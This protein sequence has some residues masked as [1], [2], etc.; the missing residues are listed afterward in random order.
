MGSVQQQ[1]GAEELQNRF[2]RLLTQ[3]AE[4]K[5]FAKPSYVNQLLEICRR[6]LGSTDGV[7]FLYNEIGN[8]VDAGIFHQTDWQHPNFLQ[9]HLTH[10]AFASSNQA[11]ITLE[12]LS[13][14]RWLALANGD[15]AQDHVSPDIARNF[16]REV[17]ALN[18]DLVFKHSTETSRQRKL[19]GV[20]HLFDFLVA[21]IGYGD[22]LEQVVNEVWRILKQRP[23]INNHIIAMITQLAVCVADPEIATPRGSEGLVSA[24]FG[25]TPASQTDPGLEYYQ[26]S[27]ES[28]DTQSLQMEAGAF[29]RAMHDTGLVSVYHTV[30]LRYVLSQ[31]STELVIQALGLSSTGTDSYMTYRELVNRLITDA[32]T[33]NTAQAVI[34]LAC[35][36]ERGILFDPSLAP[37]FWRLI[38]LNLHPE[39]EADIYNAYGTAQPAKTVL[40]AGALLVLGL[41]FGIGQ[42][43]NPTCQAARALS[44]WSYSDPN[45][46]MQIIVWAS[47][48]QDVSMHF[49][50]QPI[51]SKNL[52][53]E[54]GTTF[55]TELDPVSLVTVP[56]LDRIYLEM[57]RLS[58]GRGEDPHK[59]VNPEFHGWW[60]GQGFAIAVDINT[61]NLINH[62]QFIRDFYAFYHPYFNGNKP[63]IYPQPAGIAITDSFGDYV[64]WHAITIIRVNLDIQGIM[65]VYF[66]NPNN[67]S[68]QDWGN[69]VKVST[70]GNGELYGQSSL[71]IEQF[72]SRLYIFHYDP[73]EK[74]DSSN[75]EQEE[76]DAICTMARESWA[77]DRV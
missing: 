55:H 65:R 9:S 72:V 64:G 33:P 68:G 38:L 71:P 62:E 49:E 54:S 24:L 45:Y 31:E 69:S 4:A 66:F 2:A 6:L 26:Q 1:T 32:V 70:D 27:L 37:N 20:Y 39:T 21:H 46:L 23:I 34:G 5:A 63:V 75:L 52:Q 50:G 11:T 8:L 67:D 58:A 51:H 36:L 76:V 40:L 57:G 59:W 3:L 18:L 16:L 77:A 25:P 48:D 60:V 10:Q 56:H 17:L 35:M 73:L 15:Y 14:L 22:I 41:P 42:G 12:C 61:G 74:G 13:E 28:M 43:D 30:Y 53:I 7:Q 29:A 44:M 19:T 47:R